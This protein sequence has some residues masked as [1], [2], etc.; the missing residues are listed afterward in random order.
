[1]S[2]AATKRAAGSRVNW[3]AI[4][5][6]AQIIL[7]ATFIIAFFTMEQHRQT[8]LHDMQTELH[9]LRSENHR[10]SKQIML[11]TKRRAST[12]GLVGGLEDDDAIDAVANG[13][14]DNAGGDQEEEELFL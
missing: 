5:F 3:L 12:E 13:A 11:S 7:F 4:T 1:M 10:V 8:E 9:R 14:D 2:L 6:G